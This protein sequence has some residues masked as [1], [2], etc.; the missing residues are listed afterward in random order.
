MRL[1][2]FQFKMVTMTWPICIYGNMVSVWLFDLLGNQ[3]LKFLYVSHLQ[4]YGLDLI[5]LKVAA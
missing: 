5:S 2:S 1:T 4:L 3:G